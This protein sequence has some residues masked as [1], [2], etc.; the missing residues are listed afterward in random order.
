[1]T[2]SS[3]RLRC[4]NLSLTQFFSLGTGSYRFKADFGISRESSKL[5]RCTISCARIIR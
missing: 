5:K 2:P 4:V 3:A 1:M